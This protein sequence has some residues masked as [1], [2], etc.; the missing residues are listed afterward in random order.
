[1]Y[2]LFPRGKIARWAQKIGPARN[3]ER[4][5]SGECRQ[6]YTAMPSVRSVMQSKMIERSAILLQ[7]DILVLVKT[8]G[9]WRC[10]DKH[11]D[12]PSL[13]IFC[14]HLVEVVFCC[15]HYI[16]NFEKGSFLRMWKVDVFSWGY[17]LFNRY[18]WFSFFATQPIRDNITSHFSIVGRGKNF[19]LTWQ[20][21]TRS[22]QCSCALVVNS[23][24]LFWSARRTT[25]NQ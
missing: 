4:R 7:S 13:A 24:T 2:L 16:K 11:L 19:K 25:W 10:G 12:F 1:M 6:H 17:S 23:R 15:F 22:P 3:L 8:G 21:P 5:K 14:L 18:V 20:F 9:S